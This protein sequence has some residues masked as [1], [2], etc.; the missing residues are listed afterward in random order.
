MS[1]S[2]NPRIEAIRRFNRFYTRRIGVLNQGLLD[3]P[4]SL[5]EV[6]LMY[7]LASRESSTPT[8]LGRALEIDAGYLSRLL[9]GLERRGLIVRLPSPGDRRQRR[10]RLT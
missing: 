7:E 1:A 5:A 9:R 10:L 6:R 8:E 3:S 4:F 2:P